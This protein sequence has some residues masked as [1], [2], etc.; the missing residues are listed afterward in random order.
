MKNF[1]DGLILNADIQ[2]VLLKEAKARFDN[3]KPLFKNHLLDLIDHNLI[4]VD[5]AKNYVYISTKSGRNQ[6]VVTN[7]GS[8]TEDANKHRHTMK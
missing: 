5:E 4:T 3:N 6:F 7:T 1:C 8:N 2:A